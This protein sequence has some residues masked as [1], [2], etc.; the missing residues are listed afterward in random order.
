M[1]KILNEMYLKGT[2]I[3]SKEI[4]NN[5]GKSV[6]FVCIY[7]N[8]IE[9]FGFIKRERTLVYLKGFK[10]KHIQNLWTI[11]PAYKEK[12][13]WIINARRKKDNQ[14]EI[15]DNTNNTI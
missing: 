8:Y 9:K 14:E 6:Q 12:V 4:A 13:L 11:N 5:I 2:P 3:T 10:G 7:L 15:N 1:P